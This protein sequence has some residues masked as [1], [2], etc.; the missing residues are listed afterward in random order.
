MN[1]ESE[2]LGQFLDALRRRQGLLWLVLGGALLLTVALALGLPPSYRSSATILIEQQEMPRELVRSTITSF[3]DQRIQL[4]SQRVMSYPN[5]LRIIKEYDLYADDRERVPSEVIIERMRRDI[6]LDMVSADVVDPRSGRPQQATIAFTLAFE[7]QFPAVAQDVAS[8]LTTLFLNENLKSRREDAEETTR[9]LTT[10]GERLGRELGQLERQLADFKAR[11]QDAL[12]ELNDFN[13]RQLEQSD[14]AL[15][16]LRREIIALEGRRMSLKAAL[17]EADKQG[18]IVSSDRN[19][20]L[21]PSRRLQ[22]VKTELASLTGLYSDN[23]PTVRALRRELKA[24]GAETGQP[25]KAAAVV[26]DELAQL[27][28]QLLEAR[29]RYAPDHPDVK[30][31]QSLVDGLESQLERPVASDPVAQMEA[32]VTRLEGEVEAARKRYAA[33]HPDLQWLE[34]VLG[35]LQQELES[36]RAEQGS[37]SAS[38]DPAYRRIEVELEATENELQAARDEADLLRDKV[39]ELEQRLMRAPMVEQEY[40]VLV[41]DYENAYS[42]YKEITAKQLEAEVAESLETERKGERFTLIEPPLLPQRPTSPNRLAILFVGSVLAVGIALGI[43]AMREALDHSVRGARGVQ[44]ATGLAPLA[45]IPP[46]IL[47]EERRTRRNVKIAVILLV[48]LLL[49]AVPIA[50]HFLVKPLDVIWHIL[51]RRWGF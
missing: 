34:L 46:V 9:F 13:R 20:E 43:V 6:R 49:I 32:E 37:G 16:Q 21:S 29:R 7:S 1:E 44:A 40:R 39:A 17:E 38:A 4:I 23:H 5:L 41:R 27:R 31:L 30:W 18:G 11:H 8:E 25:I 3:A 42:K 33:N 50:V 14:R 10:E 26:T 28:I 24:L 15:Q 19:A 48:V 35:S 22:Q 45:L 12:P 51:M 36:A 47:D 2:N